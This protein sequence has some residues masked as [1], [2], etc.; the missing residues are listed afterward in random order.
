MV[1]AARDVVNGALSIGDFVLVNTFLIQ[2]YLPLNFLGFVYGQI[3]QS[4]ID[5]D[6]MFE[7]MDVRTEIEDADDA[8]ALQLTQGE[9]VFENVYFAYN[10]DR[11]ILKHITFTIPAS[12]IVAIVG[13]SGSGKSTISRLLFRCYDIDS[14]A[15][16]I[17]GQ[18]I[19]TISQASLP[20][21]TVLFNDT[22]AYNIGYGDPSKS[23]EQ[24]VEA[25]ELAQ[26]HAFIITLPQVYDTIVGERGLKLSGGEKL[27]VA[28]AHTMLKDPP[29]LLFDEATSALDSTT[30]QS[31]QSSLGLVSKGRTTLVIAHRLST[32][33]NADNILVLKAGKIVA[34]GYHQQLLTRDGEYAQMWQRQQEESIY[35][36]KLEDCLAESD[37]HKRNTA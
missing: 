29:I 11:A 7:L 19:Q 25:A 26:I 30:E 1:M 36:T 31:I 21:D 4:L 13:P 33:V 37:N 10:P 27:R 20:Q 24:I 22:I 28:I 3:R 35:K 6:K 2:L 23:Q 5:M 14:G 18:N 16:R 8:K 34:Q 17:D 32:I 9:V 15:I 12:N